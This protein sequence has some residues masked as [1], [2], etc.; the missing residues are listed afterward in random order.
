MALAS[1]GAIEELKGLDPAALTGPELR[2]V[3]G[4][5]QRLAAGLDAAQTRLTAAFDA[6]GDWALD[7]ARTVAAWLAWAHHLPATAAKARVALGR[8]LRDLP[9]AEATWL[10]GEIDS[11]H[12]RLLA[13]ARTEVTAEYFQRD[14]QLLVDAACTM[15]YDHFARA[16]AYWRQLADPDGVEADSNLLH[17]RRRA[18]VS[19]SFEGLL[20][21]D[22]VLDPIAGAVFKEELD[23]ITD[24]LFRADWTEAQAAAGE[25]V[26]VTRAAVNGRR[27]PAQRRADALVEMARRAATAPAGG[28][29]PDPLFTVLV[30][31][32]TLAGRIC[33]LA[34]GTVVA[35]GSLL[36][37]LDQAHIE[38]VVFDGP[39]RVIDV[40]ERR[41]CFDG[42]T[43]RAIEVRDRECFH[44]T[45]DTPAD[46]CQVDHVEPFAA[47]G[48]TTQSNGRLA[49]GPHNRR[50]HA[51]RAPATV[52]TRPP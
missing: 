41:R 50:R 30:G 21:G 14:E 4:E 47:G 29:R 1:S 17:E 6:S 15:R 20:F 40:G 8:A 18:H 12:V 13:R 23:Q 9:A 16:V 26:E 7:G 36:P 45:C 39:S 5:V 49:C 42:A 24:E 10:T 38:R 19:R 43:R 33:E 2:A 11:H 35:P 46:R 22:F 25:G 48:L 37:W 31:Y 34:D 3:L 52:V 27:S 44:P 28:R 32:E 51:P